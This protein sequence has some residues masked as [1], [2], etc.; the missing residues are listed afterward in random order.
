MARRTAT[1]VLLLAAGCAGG[2]TQYPGTAD[3]ARGAA[4]LIEF[5]ATG[6][7]EAEPRLLRMPRGT[8]V[9]FRNV[10][11]GQTFVRFEQPVGTLC[12]PPVGFEP[13]HDGRTVA[14]R[15][16]PPFAET[17]LCLATPGRYDYVV[18][19]IE[20]PGP[21]VLRRADEPAESPVLYGTIVV[22]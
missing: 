2:A 15:A 14:S 5:R 16:M 12:G 3:V 9:V 20:P 10:S 8:E 6:S 11:R 17:R 19:R 18:S 7:T 4:P 22:E 1:L 13:T 21:S